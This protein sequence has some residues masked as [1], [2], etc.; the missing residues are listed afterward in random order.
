MMIFRNR[1]GSSCSGGRKRR[2]GFGGSGLAQCQ[3]LGFSLRWFS[4]GFSLGFSF[5]LS[6]GL[7][8]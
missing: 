6:F 2:L 3:S 5:G 8:V 7:R 1:P 4:L